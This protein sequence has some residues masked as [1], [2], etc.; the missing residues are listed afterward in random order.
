MYV[1]LDAATTQSGPTP[2]SVSNTVTVAGE[3]FDESLT[4]HIFMLGC[5]HSWMM[6]RR[7]N[8]PE[9]RERLPV[10][11]SGA[12]LRERLPTDEGDPEILDASIQDRV[13]S[14]SCKIILVKD[15]LMSTRACHTIPS[16]CKDNTSNDPFSRCKSVQEFGYR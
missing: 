1:T 2:G 5:E 11:R 14:C 8:D 4:E 10:A 16:L 12:E 15:G 3:K 6:K 7:N 13:R 9:L